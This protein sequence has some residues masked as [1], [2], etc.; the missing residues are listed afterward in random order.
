[1]HFAGATLVLP[2]EIGVGYSR[3][4]HETSRHNGIAKGKAFC[5]VP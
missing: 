5:P 4:T 1:M 3:W 2:P